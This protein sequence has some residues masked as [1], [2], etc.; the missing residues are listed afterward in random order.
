MQEIMLRTKRLL[1]RRYREADIP[2]LVELLGAKEVAATTLRI[3]HPYTEQDARNFLAAQESPAARFG[4]FEIEGGNL[5]GGLGLAPDEPYD[6]AELG[7][8]VGLPYWGRGYATEAAAE[9]LRHGFEDLKLNRI[10]AAVFEG[11]PASEKVL[12]KLGFTL[13]GTLRQQFKKWGKYL[14]DKHYGILA[15]DWKAQHL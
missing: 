9:M 2:V 5:V 7:Y 14:D 6:R 13:E 12:L 4:M 3:P 10:T 8:W 1:M 11:N 15:S